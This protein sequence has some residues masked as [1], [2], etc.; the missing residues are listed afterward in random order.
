MRAAIVYEGSIDVRYWVT[1]EAIHGAALSFIGDPVLLAH[2]K[3]DPYQR[4]GTIIDTA[5]RYDELLEY[6]FI[7]A[8]LEIKDTRTI[9]RI[10]QGL[11]NSLSISFRPI[12][13]TCN[14]D[15]KDMH[16]CVHAPGQAHWEKGQYIRPRG[17]L[18]SFTGLEV[19]FI[20]VPASEHARILEWSPSPLELSARN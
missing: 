2:N 18:H 7:E 4:V 13:V 20:N 9:N 8:I 19:S 3:S 15:G 5:P 12:R 17:I 11:F 6:W 10:Q 14:A 1:D 16:K